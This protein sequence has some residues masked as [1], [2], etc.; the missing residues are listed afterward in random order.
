[1]TDAAP[2]GLELP[3]WLEAQQKLLSILTDEQ[4]QVVLLGNVHDDFL[5]SWS[6]AH[7]TPS[8][9]RVQLTPVLDQPF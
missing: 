3:T 7:Y 5:S 4:H 2:V 1:V 9:S 8:R 6:M